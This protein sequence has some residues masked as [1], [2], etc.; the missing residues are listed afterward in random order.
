MQQIG[1]DAVNDRLC[2]GAALDKAESTGAPAMAIELNDGRV[3][4]G[5]TSSLLGSSSAALLNALKAVAGLDKEEEIISPEILAPIQ[6]LKTL[7]LGN[8]NP[9]LHTDEVLIALAISAV[10]SPSAAKAMAALPALKNAEA[11]STVILS[12]VDSSTY[13]KLGIQLSCEPKYQTKKLYHNN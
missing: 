13:R 7:N 12:Q 10:E 5:K 9:R 6:V 3:V 4:T 8:H 11:H 2:V 1:C